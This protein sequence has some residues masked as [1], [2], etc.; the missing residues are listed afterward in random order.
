MSDQSVTLTFALMDPPYET[1]R[2]GNALRL[3]EAAL[4]KGYHVNVVAYEGVVSRKRHRT[5]QV[6]RGAAGGC[7]LEYLEP[8]A[9]ALP[10]EHVVRDAS[11]APGVVTPTA[12]A[13]SHP[14]HA[15]PTPSAVHRRG[16]TPRQS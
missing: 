1:A 6:F 13:A 5:E 7:E 15:D 10:L 11:T 12:S 3:M 2:V 8:G 4:R 9:V 14:Q 16:A